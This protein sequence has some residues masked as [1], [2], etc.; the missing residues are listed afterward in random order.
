MARLSVNLNK[1]ALLRNARRTGVP[2]VLAFGR[3]ARQAGA[4]GLTVHPRPD[5]RHVRRTDVPA[6]AEM[7]RPWRPAFEFNIEGYPDAAFMAI[8]ESIRPE[9]C[10][11]VPDAPDTFTSEEGWRLDE[12]QR[13]IVRDAI[14]RLKACGT[15]GI[16]FV[17]P[18][19]SMPERVAALG[20]DGIEIYT[21][22]YAQAFT[23]GDRDTMLR[24]CAE[25]AAEAKR[26][27]LLVNVGHDLNLD[28]LPPLVAAMPDLH[29]ASIGHELTVDALVMGWEP[30]VAAYVAALRG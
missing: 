11:L 22:S 29:E 24:R 17:D 21:G 15:R 10:T 13:P 7:M 23:S 26:V 1:I 18:D 27:G 4:E 9:Q 8:V 16:V 28:N 14:A 5:E 25:T 2:D 3:L 30:A 12:A 20:A 19:P 6:L